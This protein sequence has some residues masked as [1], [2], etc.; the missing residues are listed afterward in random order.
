MIIRKKI[1]KSEVSC[2][3]MKN[4]AFIYYGKI[5]EIK[6]ELVSS[7]ISNEENNKV[8]VFGTL[9]KMEIDG[10]M[11]EFVCSYILS[12]EYL[13]Q[14]CPVLVLND[15]QLYMV[16]NKKNVSRINY[17]SYVGRAKDC[18]MRNYLL[19][20][21]AFLCFYKLQN[22][23]NNTLLIICAIFFIGFYLKENHHNRNNKKIYFKVLNKNIKQMFLLRKKLK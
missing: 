9:I 19:L 7:E 6:I 4:E 11:K 23:T 17:F 18:L 2:S 14:K 1:E 16:I 22:P 10:D 5:K 20:L 8:D 21:F 12:S 13:D 15:N 3:D